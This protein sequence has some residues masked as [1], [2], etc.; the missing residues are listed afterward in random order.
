MFNVCPACGQYRA[1]KRIDP[2]GPWAICP[3][4]GHAHR[5]RL[6][7]LL[8]VGGASGTGKSTAGLLLPGR[9]PGAVVLEADI[10]W[11]P[12]FDHQD[13]GYRPFFETWLR[14]AKSIAQSGPNVMVVGAGF[15]VPANLES[16]IERRY[17]SALHYLALVCDDRV[18]AARLRARPGWRGS[19]AET[20]IEGQVS[21][22]QWLKTQ[23]ADAATTASLDTTHASPADVARGILDWAGAI[24]RQGDRA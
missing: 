9:L 13:E 24:L 11:G 16:C 8:L 12:H 6:S 5:F 19:S 21:F 17:F 22:N 3:E 14:T 18:L 10:L 2:A 15:A 23:A 7:P 1:D 20:F 4:C